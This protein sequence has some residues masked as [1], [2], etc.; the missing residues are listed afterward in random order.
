M[1]WADDFEVA[2]FLT[3][4]S[5]RHSIL[6]KLKTAKTEKGRLGTTDGKL[7][8]TEDA[9]V[10]VGE[11]APGLITEEGEDS[12]GVRMADIPSAAGDEALDSATLGKEESQEGLFVS[13]D[14]DGA[15]V[16]A[17]ETPS[18]RDRG[19][20]HVGEEEDGKGGDK[21]KLGMETTYDGFSIYGR[22]LCL[23]VKRKGSAKGKGVAGGTGQAM[24]EEWIASTQMQDGQ[25]MD[26]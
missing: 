19:K 3:E 6:R 8:S 20:G 13:D 22:I 2:V 17:E 9:P 5:S 12:E 16:D 11:G 23:V 10:E 15:D 25:M 1:R 7:T 14:S 4:T 24:M 21:K 18:S 26:E